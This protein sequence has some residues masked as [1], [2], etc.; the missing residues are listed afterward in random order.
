MAKKEDIQNQKDLN[1]E[2]RETANINR[3][4]NNETSRTKTLEEQIIELLSTRRGINSDVLSDQQDI[5][6]SLQDQVKQQ[7]FI[8]SE[9]RLTRDLSNSV[10]KIAQ[11]A[12]SIT[13]KELGLSKTANDLTKQQE[14]LEKNIILAKQQ[15]AKF[16]EM[17]N[18]G[19]ANSKRLNAE[20]ANSLGD[21]AKQAKEVARQI[22]QTVESSDAIAKTG[23]VKAFGLMGDV[24]E[25][26]GMS[27][28]AGPVKEAAEA[29]RAHGAEQIE[30]NAGINKG[31]GDYK[32]FR[33]EGMKM[34]DALKKA[35]VSAK[36]VKVG[37]L[38]L[39]ASG[40]LTAGF[41][42]LGPILKKAMGP[43]GLITEAVQAFIAN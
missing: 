3:D 7:Q 5:A 18:S 35:G 1:N 28:I 2:K 8:T 37:K 9:K 21:Q 25:K 29:A 39:K 32:Q 17:S 27:K 23:G 12:Y 13:S 33:A 16:S 34:G 38:P 42:A 43:L 31:I 11:E 20:I 10:T 19:D 15:Q 4:I 24:A 41:K 6:N 30:M 14:T 36:Q 40:T 22:A 26:L